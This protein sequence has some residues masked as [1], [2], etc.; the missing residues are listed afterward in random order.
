MESHSVLAANIIPDSQDP[1]TACWVNAAVPIDLAEVLAVCSL[2]HPLEL[3]ESGFTAQVE[4]VPT[5]GGWVWR[6][7]SLPATKLCLL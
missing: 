6:P 7:Q 1:K 2:F 5:G 4:V 3:A